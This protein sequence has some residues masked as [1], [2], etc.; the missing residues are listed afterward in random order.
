MDGSVLAERVN[1][2]G[3]WLRARFGCDVVKIGLDAGLGCPNRDHAAGRGGCSF[4]P[5]GGAGQR[6][7]GRA[8]ADQIAEGVARLGKRKRPAQALAYFQAYSSTHGPAPRLAALYQEAMDAPGV[9]GLVI[10]T[11]PDCLDEARWAVLEDVNQATEMWL[12]LGLQS[13]HDQTLAAIGRG[14][15][16]ACF[17]RAVARAHQAGIRV[18]A[19]VILGLP[20]EGVEQTNATAEHLAG[21]GVWGVKMHHLMVLA[22]T[23]LAEQHQA[24]E[25]AL[26]SRDDFIAGAAGFLARLPGEVLVHRLAADPGPDQ[27]LAPDWAGDKDA[28]LAGLADYLITHDLR[29]GSLAHG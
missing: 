7:G 22:R 18:V 21:L 28:I 1:L 8:I 25:L 4:C 26:W 5:P 2:L 12:E 27:L 20:G 9:S 13:A 15:D 11:R 23:R 6:A 14:H 24:G 10:S 19:H 17:D 29:Q 16:L 3:P